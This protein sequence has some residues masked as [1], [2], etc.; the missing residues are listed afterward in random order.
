MLGAGIPKTHLPGSPGNE[1]RRVGQRTHVY[2]SDAPKIPPFRGGDSVIKDYPELGKSID[3]LSFTP[4]AQ[5]VTAS[6]LPRG[7]CEGLIWSYGYHTAMRDIVWPYGYHTAIH[8]MTT[9]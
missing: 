4:I 9:L 8:D 1:T 3:P 7:G 2:G 5:S 6:H